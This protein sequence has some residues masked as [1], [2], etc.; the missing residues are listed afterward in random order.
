MH[1]A[2][3]HCT[4]SDCMAGLPEG[5]RPSRLGL[6]SAGCATVG[7]ELGQAIA[8]NADVKYMQA[9]ALVRLTRPTKSVHACNAMIVA[10]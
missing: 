7:S 8:S 5:N 2:A 3:G 1:G 6:A 10:I 4:E 9:L